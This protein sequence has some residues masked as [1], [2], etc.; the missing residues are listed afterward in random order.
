VPDHDDD[1]RRMLREFRTSTT[2]EF[3]AVHNRIDGLDSRIDAVSRDLGGRIE[4]LRQEMHQDLRTWNTTILNA[5]SELAGRMDRR[6][7][8]LEIRV[9]GLEE[10]VD[11]LEDAG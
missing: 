1:L 2:H 8:R 7:D 9:D 4:R 6:F 11:G 10:R 5:I 3:A